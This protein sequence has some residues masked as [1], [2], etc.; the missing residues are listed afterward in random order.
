MTEEFGTWVYAVTVGD[1]TIPP[2]LAGVGGA[3][4]RAVPAAGLVAVVSAVDLAEYGEEPLRRNLENLEWLEAT[5]RAHHNV[6]DAVAEAGQTVP[7][8]MATLYRG[9]ERVAEML[10][11]RRDDFLAALD[12]VR[13]RTEWGIKIYLPGS[14]VAAPTAGAARMSG[15]ARTAGGADRPGA[16]FLQ[17]RRSELAAREHARAAAAS[18]AEE[19]HAELAQ[20]SAAARLHKPQHPQLTGRSEPMILNA[21]YLVD[22]DRGGEFSAAADELAGRHPAVRLELTGPWPPYSFTVPGE[23][24]AASNAGSVGA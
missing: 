7:M 3:P 5:A 14:G 21:T 13:G 16:A 4:L 12:K 20:L 18:S 11:E 23:E 22:D 10:A 1:R 15:T 24:E 9:D 6:I 17:R 8:Q 2:G 19:I